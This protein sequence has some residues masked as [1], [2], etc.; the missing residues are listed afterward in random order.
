MLTVAAIDND[1]SPNNIIS[2]SLI[3]SSQNR[4]RIDGTSGEIVVNI[5]LGAGTIDFETSTSHTLIVQSSDGTLTDTATVYIPIGDDNDNDPIFLESSY[6]IQ[7]LESAAIG[8]TI[9][10]V[11]VFINSTSLFEQVIIAQNRFSFL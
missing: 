6:S 4:F 7:V 5:Q 11:Q 2:Y 10:A 3:D 9:L 1:I 8:T